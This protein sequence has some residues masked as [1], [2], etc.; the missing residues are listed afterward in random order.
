ML[1]VYERLDNLCKNL[2]I[3]MLKIITW[4]VEFSSI[5]MNASTK[6][7]QWRRDMIC[8]TWSPR[9]STTVP[10]PAGNS[11]LFSLALHLHQC[12]HV[13]C[14]TL[15]NMYLPR[16]CFTEVD[17]I[18]IIIAL[19]TDMFHSP[20]SFYSARSFFKILYAT[21]CFVFSCVFCLQYQQLSIGRYL[22]RMSS[23]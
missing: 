17:R 1:C 15:V 2:F 20:L 13:H 10:A 3:F 5:W 6:S 23:K 12:N 8:R 4:S 11:E 9:R 16:S 14:P 18:W 21:S 22:F 7:L 19:S